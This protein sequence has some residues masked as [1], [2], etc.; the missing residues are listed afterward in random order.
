MLLML[1]FNVLFSSKIYTDINLWRNAFV[2]I[3]SDRGQISVLITFTRLLKS[4]RSLPVTAAGLIKFCKLCIRW[5]NITRSADQNNSRYKKQSTDIVTVYTDR[6]LKKIFDVA[7]LTNVVETTKHGDQPTEDNR[8]K[9][10]Q[11]QNQRLLEKKD[12]DTAQTK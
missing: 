9:A 12:W 6:D 3:V 8:Y 2:F 10:G 4:W 11:L 5:I 7:L 1:T